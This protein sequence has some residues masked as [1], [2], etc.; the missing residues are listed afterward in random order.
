MKDPAFLLYS[1]DFLI[2]CVDLTA[3]ETG[4]YIKLLCLQH[5]KGHLSEKTISLFFG[6]YWLNF[7]EELRAKFKKDENGMIYN[8]RLEREI[9]NRAYNIDYHRKNGGKG[10]APKGNRNA[11]KQP[12]N[13]QEYNQET[14]K[15]QASRDE[16]V[17]VNEDENIDINIK[18]GMGEN[19]ETFC[20]VLDELDFENVWAM[21]QRKG[22]KKS[23]KRRWDSLPKKAKL[24]AVTHIPQYVEATPDIQYR[25][26]FETYINQEAWNDKI[27][28]RNG[29]K[30][31]S[32][33]TDGGL[34]ADLADS[35]A[36]GIARAKANKGN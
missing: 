13:N 32:K 21:Y 36:A 1:Q 23:S 33:A 30:N 20:D 19:E 27:I 25:K 4:Y 29:N 24:I 10:G 15:K 6:C 12:K 18:G 31:D 34:N 7:S 17:N 16:D 11:K 5:Q 2:G 22:N 8:S 9:E 28:T 14:T 3:E 26:N 35:I